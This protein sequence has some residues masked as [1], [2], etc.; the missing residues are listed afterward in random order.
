MN[1]MVQKQCCH[2]Y[3]IGFAGTAPWKVP[4]QDLQLYVYFEEFENIEMALKASR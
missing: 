3:I 2:S 4:V 1:G